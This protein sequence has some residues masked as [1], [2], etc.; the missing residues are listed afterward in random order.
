MSLSDLRPDPPFYEL[1][2]E[3]HP[4]LRCFPDLVGDEVLSLR[5]S[6]SAFSAVR[7][8]RAIGVMIYALGSQYIFLTLDHIEVLDAFIFIIGDH[9]LHLDLRQL[10]E[11][12]TR[13]LLPRSRLLTLRV[14]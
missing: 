1:S 13:T 4:I 3:I 11:L 12:D 10:L 7:L 8:E 14:R 6:T 2:L 5:E 9:K